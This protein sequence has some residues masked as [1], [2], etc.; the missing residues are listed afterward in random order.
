LNETEYVYVDW[1]STFS[2]SHDMS[3]PNLA[4]PGV[5]VDLGPL[6]L[7]YILRTG[8][9]GYFRMRTA[10][11]YLNSGQLRLVPGAPEF[12]YP[13]YAVYPIDGDGDL[14]GPAL[15]ALR[16]VSAAESNEWPIGI[17]PQLLEAIAATNDGAGARGSRAMRRARRGGA[18]NRP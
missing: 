11:P 18:D 15:E 2:A 8:G 6:G 7:G 12:F 16:D 4:S 3:F 14:L 1:G 9:S 5:H 17:G 10:Q 13:V